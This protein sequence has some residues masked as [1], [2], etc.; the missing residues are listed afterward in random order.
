MSG[1]ES[2]SPK[3]V[4]KTHTQT[5]KELSIFS[6]FLRSLRHCQKSPADL[7]PLIDS[8]TKKFPM[9]YYFCS[10]K[11]LSEFIVN[12]HYQYFDQ[13]RQKLGHRMDVSTTSHIN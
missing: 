4:P 1:T 8:S 9:Y 6:K 10:N 5:T 13:I 7:G 2:K 12:A 11:P 3:H